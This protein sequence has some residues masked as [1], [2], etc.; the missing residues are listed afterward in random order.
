[1]NPPFGESVTTVNKG[2]ESDYPN[3]KNDIYAAFVDRA[4]GLC[5]TGGMVGAITPRTGFFLSRF[6]CWRENVLLAKSNMKIVADLGFGVLDDA[7]VETVAYC[8][9]AR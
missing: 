1:M 5:I 2:F 4:L 9:E 8:L 6:K 7:M 3:S